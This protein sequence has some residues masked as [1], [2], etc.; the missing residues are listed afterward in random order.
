[1]QCA[2]ADQIKDWGLNCYIV[3][4]SQALS[5]QNTLY[6]R[7]IDCPWMND[8]CDKQLCEILTNLPDNTSRIDLL[9]QLRQ[10]LL[11]SVAQKLNCNKIFVADST[12]DIAANVLGDLCLGR[13]TQLSTL[14]A[15]CDHS[16][17]DD[18]KILK[19]IRDFT[20]QELAYYSE[21]Y[22]LHLVKLKITDPTATSIQAL[23]HNFTSGL[24]LQFSGTVSTIFHTAEKLNVK[25]NMDNKDI[26]DNCV[27]CDAKLDVESSCNRLSAMRAIKISKLLSSN[28]DNT[29][30]FNGR[31]ETDESNWCI[32]VLLNDKECGSDNS[33]K[34][35]GESNKG[36]LTP[37]DI[38]KS[39]CY[40]CKLI[41]QDADIL[42]TLPASLLSV[43]Q[44]R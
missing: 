27:L 37:K 1:M 3:S 8:D 13:G 19:P 21:C 44:E 14:A 35:D 43:I 4:L 28:H 15:F 39:L 7:P 36:Q 38:W 2:I 6:I 5:E 20:Q 32:D 12:A 24:E 10:K 25:S 29:E 22:E 16:Q 11:I 9:K 33:N 17:S 41:F 42:C 30:I 23:V 26:E 34:H 40:S 31:E 18:I